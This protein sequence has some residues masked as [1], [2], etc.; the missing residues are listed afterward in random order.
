MHDNIGRHRSK[1]P[2]TPSRPLHASYNCFASSIRNCPDKYIPFYG[3][4]S[5]AT[6]ASENHRLRTSV[7]PPSLN[8]LSF[9][10]SIPPPSAATAK[11]SQRSHRPIKAKGK[12]GNP[13]KLVFGRPDIG[14]YLMKTFSVQPRVP[15]TQERR[16][17][18][19]SDL[20]MSVS[21]RVT[22]RADDLSE[23][24]VREIREPCFTSGHYYHI[25]T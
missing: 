6:E 4:R 1:S 10:P 18:T 11:Q 23:L 13:V 5:S 16:G 24:E 14:A 17:R 3:S 7:F 25:L 15:G 22:G 19:T 21:T 20:G 12:T 2:K 8:E 9:P